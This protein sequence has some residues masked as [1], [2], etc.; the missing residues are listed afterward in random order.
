M[1]KCC[2]FYKL[3]FWDNIYRFW[4]GFRLLKQYYYLWVTFDN[5]WGSGESYQNPWNTQLKVNFN[6]ASG[7]Y[8]GNYSTIFY[9][10]GNISFCTKWHATKSIQT[11]LNMEN[12]CLKQKFDWIE[13][14][15]LI[16]NT[17]FDWTSLKYFF[18]FVFTINFLL[19]VDLNSECAKCIICSLR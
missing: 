14:M 19:Q 3:G 6:G 1:I 18:W 11:W 2:S 9:I 15:W 16:D 5:F 8:L 4:H 12:N 7:H 17:N 13:K 10:K